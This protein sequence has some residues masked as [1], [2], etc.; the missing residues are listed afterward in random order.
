[1]YFAKLTS[2]NMSKRIRKG[3]ERILS[4]CWNAVHGSNKYT[5][6][7]I[8]LVPKSYTLTL[9]VPQKILIDNQMH[10][11]CVQQRTNS[12]YYQISLPRKNTFHPVS[13]VGTFSSTNSASSGSFASS[14]SSASSA[15]NSVQRSLMHFSRSSREMHE[16]IPRKIRTHECRWMTNVHTIDGTLEPAVQ[17]PVYTGPFA[18]N[19]VHRLT[20]N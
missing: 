1:M 4:R 12:P 17:F 13:Q 19:C 16:M 10:I 7:T 11:E 8:A 14:A 2:T 20:Q 3:N 9:Q 15:C 18:S 5:D 6:T